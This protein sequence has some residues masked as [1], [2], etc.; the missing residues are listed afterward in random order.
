MVVFFRPSEAEVKGI[1]IKADQACVIL[2]ENPGSENPELYI[3]DP[4]RKA[5]E[6]NIELGTEKINIQLP[7]AL[8]YAGSSVH[9]KKTNP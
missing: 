3:T 4:S 8:D 2:I 6:V 1:K 5:K 9:Y 7:V